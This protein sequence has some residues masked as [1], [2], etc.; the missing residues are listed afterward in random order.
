MNYLPPAEYYKNLPRKY[1]GAGALF[2]NSENQIL[3][4]KPKYKE[5]WEIPGGIVEAEEAPQDACYREIKEEINLDIKPGRLLVLDFRTKK[6]F[7]GDGIMLVFFGGILTQEQ[8][9]QIKLNTDEL[10]EFKFTDIDNASSLVTERLIK[11]L[12]KAM[13]AYRDNVCLVLKDGEE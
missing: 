2:F 3:I 11:R 9:N 7:M 6:G 12:P 10:S 5:G 1:I 13:R 8:I 4:V